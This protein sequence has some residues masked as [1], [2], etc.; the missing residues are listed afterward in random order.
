MGNGDLKIMRNCKRLIG[1]VQGYCW[2]PK[3]AERGMDAPLKRADHLLDSTRYA[4]FSYFGNK[5]SLK[6]PAQEVVN[7]RAL[8]YGAFKGNQYSGSIP[9]QNFDTLEHG[10]NTFHG[11]SVRSNQFNSIF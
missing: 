7:A 10:K 5:F 3:A 9:I 8:G 1:E 11:N 6:Q 4:I 2:D